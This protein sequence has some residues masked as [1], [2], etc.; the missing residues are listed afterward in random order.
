MRAMN[1]PSAAR[2][3]SPRKTFDCNVA[4]TL[5][6]FYTPLRTWL[7]RWYPCKLSLKFDLTRNRYVSTDYTSGV[8]M[9]A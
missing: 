9:Q 7:S 8:G 4:S 3:R 1:R 2:R 6:R 5:G